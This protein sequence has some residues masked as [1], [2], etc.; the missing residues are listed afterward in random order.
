MAGPVKDFK[1][2][3][4]WQVA[5]QFRTEMYKVAGTLPDFEKFAL[6]TQIR[7]AASSI[8]ANIAE[9]FGRFGY[10]ENAQFCRQARGSL[11][12]LRDHLTTCID[13]GY[14]GPKEGQRLDAL[15]QRVAQVLNGYLRSTLAL[16][17]E[18]SG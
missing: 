5:R 2:L 11:F 3:D 10:Q 15:A 9:G 7:R 13:Q 14:I 8:T 18:V 6:A 12:E 16:K 1:D 17:V 4:V